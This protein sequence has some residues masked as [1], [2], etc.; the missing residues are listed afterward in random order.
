M[1]ERYLINTLQGHENNFSEALDPTW[2]DASNSFM[3]EQELTKPVTVHEFRSLTTLIRDAISSKPCAPITYL[4]PWPVA[5]DVRL[6]A[7]S[8]VEPMP[9]TSVTSGNT[10]APTAEALCTASDP[11]PAPPLDPP[12]AEQCVPAQP[13]AAGACYIPD[14]RAR[15]WKRAIVQWHEGEPALG[16]KALKL[17]EPELYQGR[18]KNKVATKRQ[19]R[20]LVAEEYEL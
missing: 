9:L 17:W 12:S 5:P 18:R 4:S 8:N 14:L 11:Y 15:E 7:S 1:L 6:M 10:A 2:N 16:L 19:S 20:Q 13:L 3:G